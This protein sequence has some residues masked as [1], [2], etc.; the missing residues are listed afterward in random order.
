MAVE[1]DENPLPSYISHNDPL[2]SALVTMICRQLTVER[3]TFG[4]LLNAYNCVGGARRNSVFH[5][6]VL[7]V[8]DIISRCPAKESHDASA[9]NLRDVRDYLFFKHLHRLPDI[10][11]RRFRQAM[12][13]DVSARLGREALRSLNDSVSVL[14]S[15]GGSELLR[16]SSKLRFVDELEA[17]S[18]G[19]DGTVVPG[20]VMSLTVMASVAN[21]DE[22]QKKRHNGRASMEQWNVGA[23]HNV[24]SPSPVRAV[25][26]L[27]LAEDHK[28]SPSPPPQTHSSPPT[29]IS[30]SRPNGSRQLQSDLLNS[31]SATSPSPGD[32][33]LAGGG[34]GGTL[35]PSA[36]K[37][38]K[39]PGRPRA[40]VGV[41]DGAA[42][43]G[44]SGGAT[45]PASTPP[46][47]GLSSSSNALGHRDEFISP[48]TSPNTGEPSLTN[49]HGSSSGNGTAITSPSG[50]DGTVLPMLVKQGSF[51]QKRS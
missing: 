37:N 13:D 45:S 8:F 44:S 19:C 10:F 50:A 23:N 38:E 42:A 47:N 36:P 33:G 22:K 4:Y 24:N 26:P 18:G 1:G 31:N 39:P 43:S 46:S 16:S 21:A 5:S 27:T 15:T 25:A 49:A 3:D 2:S 12:L 28:G 48:V 9:N 17:A 6:S 30:I 20:S 14:S 11:A 7:A 29:T 41:S 51:S 32:G 35:K 40:F 34:V